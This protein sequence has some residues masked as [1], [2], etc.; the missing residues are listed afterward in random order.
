MSSCAWGLDVAIV[1][2]TVIIQSMIIIFYVFRG[3]SRVLGGGGCLLNSHE[4]GSHKCK[5]LKVMDQNNA[6]IRVVFYDYN[7]G[8]YH[9]YRQ[10]DYSAQIFKNLLQFNEIVK[11]I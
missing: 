5:H 1:C 8:I 2:L 6:I 11:I 10:D 3:G 4:G 9:V 7:T